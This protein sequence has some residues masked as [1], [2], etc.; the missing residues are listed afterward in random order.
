M[1]TFLKVTGFAIIDEIQIEFNRGFNVITGETGAGKSIIINALSTLIKAKAS[2]EMVRS[3]AS[4]AEVTGHF[5]RGN[6]EYLLKRTISAS[7]RSRAMFND[8]PVT[9]NKMDEI[10]NILVNIYGQNESQNL[11]DRANY[12]EMIDDILHLKDS[13]EYLAEQVRKLREVNEKLE[14]QKKAIEGRDNEISLLEFQID[15][16]ERENIEKNEENQ[17][18]ERLK[19]LKDAEKI[20]NILASIEEGI[21]ESDNAVHG[22][23]QTFIALLRPFSNIEA[24]EGLRARFES[25]SFVIE[26]IFSEMKGMEKFLDNNPDELQKLDDK[27]A[28]LYA[29]KDKYGKTYEDIAMYKNSALKR[30]SCLKNISDNI[31][32]LENK[33]L[34]LDEKINDLAGKLSKARR[35][36]APGIERAIIDELKLLYMKGMRFVIKFTDKVAIDES[37]GD[38]IDLLISANPGEELKPLRK[39]ASGGEISRIMLAIKKVI[40]GDEERTLVF[41]EIDSGIGGR[42]ADMVGKRLKDLSK[43]HQVICITHLPQIAVYGDY[44]YLVEKVQGDRS[45]RTNIKKLSKTERVK[46]IARMIGGA[47]I[48]EKT[49]IRSEEML[50]N[51]EKSGN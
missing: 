7:G 48:T 47:V 46:E 40:G 33:K 44:H 32:D 34:L 2:S 11:L 41:D 3:N 21:Y 18:R 13:R 29:I 16:R 42:V 43:K 38:D 27:L 17:I 19:I 35:E 49:I 4:Q 1:L 28:R 8:S 37:G 51:A 39:I 36:G 9:L 25:M 14:R 26:D 50:Q 30:L 15:E 23:L 22:M 6:E 20:R 31:K 12:V 5:F 10:G 24:M 45:T